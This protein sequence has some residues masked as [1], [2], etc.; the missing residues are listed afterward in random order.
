MEDEEFRARV[1][2]V[3]EALSSGQAKLGLQLDAVVSRLDEQ[4]VVA[5]RLMEKLDRL[6]NQ[7]SISWQAA[8]QA[9]DAA[10]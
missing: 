5:D 6:T 1:L 7:V 9:I 8:E 3:L 4:D 2:E 10:E